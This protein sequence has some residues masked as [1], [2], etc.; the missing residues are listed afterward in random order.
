M[1][2]KLFIVVNE[3]WFF[4]SHRKNVAIAAINDGFD[5]TVV[6]VNTGR[7][8]DIKK[9]GIKTVEL[10]M[11]PTGMN[12]LE[13]FK[14]LLFLI[15]LYREERPDIVHHVGP[16][17]NL[18]GSLA[19]KIS[20]IPGVLNAVSGLG[21]IFEGSG[22]VS[23]IM[24]I[25]YRFVH[26]H[27][28]LLVIFQNDE[29]KS[30]Y[31][32]HNIIKSNQCRFIKGSGVDLTEF[33]YTPEPDDDRIKIMFTA[34]ML[35][36]KGPLVLRE[37]AEI[38]YGRYKDRVQ[39]ILCGGLV[40]PQRKGYVDSTELNVHNDSKYFV[41]LGQRSDVLS[42]LKQCHIFAFPSYYREGLPKSCIE[43]VSVG[44]PVVTTHSVGC[45]DT[46]IDGVSGFLVP[47]KNPVAL[48]EKL[49]ILINDK[50][51]RVSMGKAARHYAEKNFSVEEVA[52]KHVSIYN[53][54][55]SRRSK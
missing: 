38:L 7:F 35:E 19:A 45:R 23:K 36:E 48:A 13:E 52:H 8:D 51:L 12:I 26:Q 42:L 43:A 1:S 53:E 50:G 32:D 39:F 47:I 55:L 34:R 18:W 33:S 25:A 28:N 22:F 9:L 3:D 10:D 31:L 27:P 37:A 41:W 29:D 11:N 49:E 24:P 21:V 44:R 6:T 2:K 54:L 15:K 40:N 17:I 16:K 14:T 4:L 20:K 30:I 5:V 46:V